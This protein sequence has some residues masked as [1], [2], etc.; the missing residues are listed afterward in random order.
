MAAGAS[1]RFGA[2]KLSAVIN[3]KPMIEYAF[4]AV[5]AEKLCAVLTVTGYD[6]IAALS[7]ERGFCCILNRHPE[8]GLSHTIRLGTEALCKECSAILYMVS[9]QPLLSRKSVAGLIDFYLDHPDYIVSAASL[10]RRGNPCIFPEKYF[11]SLMALTGDTGGSA[12]IRSHSESLLLYE[13][14]RKE[15]LDADTP[16]AL[17]QLNTR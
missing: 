2:N 10:G 9:D 14:P 1:T 17:D 8:K 3:N 13:I 16:E 4:D 12:V 11:P 7:A 6:E 15:L 5:P